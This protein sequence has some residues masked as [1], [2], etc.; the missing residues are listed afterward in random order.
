MKLFHLCAIAFAALLDVA[1]GTTIV[2]GLSLPFHRPVGLVD[3]AL[4][5]FLALLPDIDVVYMLLRKGR[6][7]GSHHM[8]LTHRP[9]VLIPLATA[10]GW[11]LG[12]A[13]WA[14]AAFIAVFWHYVHDTPEICGSG[15][16]WFWPFTDWWWS[17]RRGLIAPYITDSSHDRFLQNWLGPSRVA[18]AEVYIAAF[19]LAL[20][21]SLI[22]DPLAGIVLGL[23]P[24]LGATIVWVLYHVYGVR[25]R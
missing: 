2:V 9:V 10:A 14:T 3:I 15:I 19:L 4:G 11:F 22:F 12:G 7:Y 5:A 21:L 23:L 1:M 24:I 13:F 6:M 18:E 20:S 17:P 8:W 16:A 25:A